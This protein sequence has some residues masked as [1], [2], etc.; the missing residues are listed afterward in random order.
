[1][2]L[3]IL[4]D[5]HGN[6]AAFERA[7]TEL[8]DEADEVLVAGDAFSDHRFSNEIVKLI[9]CAGAHYVLGNHELSFLSP[10][11]ARARESSRVSRLELDFVSRAPTELR[12]RL[13]GMRVL[14]VHGSPWPPYGRYLDPGSPEFDHADELDADLV[15]LGHTHL[16]MAR[17]VRGTLV[18]N[19]G[20]VGMSDQPGLGDSVGYALA[21]TGSGEV[22]FRTFPN[23]RRAS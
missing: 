18:V 2:K 6:L 3:G 4:A 9:R 16:P 8:A 21:D 22:S 23:P 15:V 20:S 19:P 13:G 1:M 7:L 12:V 10:A 5:A 11:N 14:M 17:R